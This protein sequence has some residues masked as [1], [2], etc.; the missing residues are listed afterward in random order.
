MVR[1]YVKVSRCPPDLQSILDE[2]NSLP[3]MDDGKW[4]ELRAWGLGTQYEIKKIVGKGVTEITAE[5]YEACLEEKREEL[6]TEFRR[7]LRELT[8]SDIFSE[9]GLT[10]FPSGWSHLQ[11]I[12]ENQDC[13][14]TLIADLEFCTV[15]A[16][17]G[18]PEA[19]EL[20]SSYLKPSRGPGFRLEFL[21]DSTL[22]LANDGVLTVL[23]EKKIPV[24]RIRL[25]GICKKIFWAKKFNA[26]TCGSK[27]C[28]DRLG[29]QRRSEKKKTPE[30][31]E[32]SVPASGRKAK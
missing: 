3:E 17:L 4:L 20:Y 12:R 23:L 16:V 1:R 14:T 19:S 21:P 8:G 29:N 6:A 31:I 32:N 2:I 5:A 25:C 18:Y 7:F 30:A 15:R 22:R 10:D 24:N 28:A 13:L 9:M 26:E 11:Q 27:S